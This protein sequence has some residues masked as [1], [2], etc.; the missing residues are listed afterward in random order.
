MGPDL[1]PRSKLANRGL[2][3]TM[4]LKG[5]IWDVDGTLCDTLPLCLAA[6]R[7]VFAKHTGKNL[8]DSEIMARFGKSEVGTIREIITDDWQAAHRDFLAVYANKHGN[9][10]RLFPGIREVL[11]GCARRGLKQ[12]IVTGKGIDTLRITLESFSLSGVFTHMET[13]SELGPVKPQGLRQI[14]KTWAV[15]P[16]EAAYVGDTSYDVS[17]AA[18]V[19]LFPLKAAWSEAVHVMGQNNLAPAAE[20]S[21]PQQLLDWLDS[22]GTTTR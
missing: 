21:H 11:D 5:L 19:G 17:S 22:I 7:E 2:Q 4:K 8:S 13:G 3:I 20:F 18:E 10:A 12:A 9:M 14:L 16:H 6:F 15:A 1:A